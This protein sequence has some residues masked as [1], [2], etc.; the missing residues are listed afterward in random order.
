MFGGF[1]DKVPPFL[2]T[3]KEKKTALPAKW[4]MYLVSTVGEMFSFPLLFILYSLSVRVHI[5]VLRIMTGDGKQ[6]MGWVV[7]RHR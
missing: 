1:S 5:H 6:F 2:C 7:G 4:Q 3:K